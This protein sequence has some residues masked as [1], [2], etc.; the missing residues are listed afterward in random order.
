VE[1][2]RNITK[3]SGRLPSLDGLRALSIGLVLFAHSYP[4]EEFQKIAFYCG[5]LGVRIFFVIS[6]FIITWLLLQEEKNSGTI[7]LRRFYTRRILRIF[8]AYYAYLAVVMLL[9]HAGIINGGR[10]IQKLLN[11]LFLANYGPCEGPTGVLWSLGVEEQFYLLW[12]GVFVICRLFKEK[13]IALIILTG[14]IACSMI[15][16]GI[17][18]L[19]WK[20]QE[21]YFW[22]HR[23]SFFFHMDII[24]W[25]CVG[26]IVAFY[27]S[28][29]V[30]FLTHHVLKVL[31]FAIF[32]ITLPYT[33][34]KIDGYGIET[35]FGPTLEALGVI[36]I[37]IMS[38][39]KSDF[40]LFRILNLRPIIWMGTISYSL[41]LWHSV[42]TGNLLQKYGISQ[43]LWVLAS[44][45][46]A[47]ISYY[48]IERPFVRYRK[49]L[50]K[51][52]N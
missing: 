25:G 24:A 6:G 12:P 8:P 19:C 42:F 26:A 10:N 50:R 41:Y 49:S 40:F 43:N 33:A 2:A 51:A 9:D 13:R 37:I 17:N 21:T 48:L 46:A 36:L 18:T 15:L 20:N 39:A 44:I 22:L 45:G 32:I 38:V 31:I 27:W 34:Q 7:S 30:E 28:K 16:R 23:F 1:T 14:V 11:I 5:T 47:M 52:G 4:P 29:I 35:V 3:N